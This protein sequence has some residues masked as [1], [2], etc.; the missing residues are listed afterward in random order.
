MIRRS[1]KV[2]GMSKLR[3]AVLSMVQAELEKYEVLSIKY[4]LGR[5]LFYVTY[6]LK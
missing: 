6:L 5:G 1:R 2:W 3:L 4:Y